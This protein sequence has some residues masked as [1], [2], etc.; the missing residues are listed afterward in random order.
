MGGWV[1]V[2]VRVFLY[3]Y[4]VGVVG[5]SVDVKLEI[6]LIHCNLFYCSN[7]LFFI[8]FLVVTKFSETIL[9]GNDCGKDQPN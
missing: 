3:M 4:C 9:R 2:C 6:N 7:H 1:C 5:V 8:Y